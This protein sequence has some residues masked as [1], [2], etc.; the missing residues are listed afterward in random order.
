MSNDVVK[1]IFVEISL[2]NFR[3]KSEHLEVLKLM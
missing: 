2:L 3:I 1:L